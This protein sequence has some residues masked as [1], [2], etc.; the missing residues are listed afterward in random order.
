MSL[1]RPVRALPAG[2]AG[3]NMS[4]VSRPLRP[5]TGESAVTTALLVIDVQQSFLHRPSWRD[6]EAVPFRARLLELIAG[7]RARGI[8][9]LHVLHEEPGSGGPFDPASG[10]VRTMEWLPAGPDAV[11]R[12][13]VHS[14]L[15]DSG[16][17]EWL[18]ARGITRLIV[19]GAPHRAVLRDDHPP[20]LGP[21]LRGHLRHRGDLDLPDRPRERAR[22]QHRG[23]PA[24]APSWCSP[25]AS[26]ASPPWPRRSR[27]STPRRPRPEPARGAMTTRVFIDRHAERA[28]A[29][30]WR[31]RPR[32]SAWRSEPGRRSPSTSAGPCRRSRRRS[33][34]RSEDSSR[35]PRRSRRET[36]SWSQA[37]RT[38]RATTLDPKRGAS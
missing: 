31:V 28:P 26:L 34:C 38:R 2:R 25:A 24:S 3:V 22:V 33:G 1:S 35:C 18:Q 7:C 20:R 16:L 21:G 5:R 37:A 4:T 17:R 27:R 23:N 8:P 11:F 9:V 12:K 29:R 13:R 14:A 10:H 32:P 30:L 36:W 6:E 15:V 19:T